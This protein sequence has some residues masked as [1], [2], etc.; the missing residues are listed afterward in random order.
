MKKAELEKRIEQLEDQRQQ[1]FKHF[2]NRISQLKKE[3]ELAHQGVQEVNQMLNAI[4][5][6]I[7]RANNGS[8]AIDKDFIGLLDKYDYKVISDND[9]YT[10][11][12]KEKKHEQIQSEE[13]RD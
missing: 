12:I 13:T 10:F 9:K 6:A 8:F 2:T 11:E 1:M 3:K 7:A 5:I 4:L